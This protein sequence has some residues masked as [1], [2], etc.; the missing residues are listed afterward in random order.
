[1]RLKIAIQERESHNS[2]FS[3]FLEEF[4]DLINERAASLDALRKKKNPIV[5][6]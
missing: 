4:H 1:M 6:Y 3:M 2:E 5:M